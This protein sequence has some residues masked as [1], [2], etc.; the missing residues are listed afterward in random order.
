MAEEDQTERGLSSFA[1]EIEDI[2]RKLDECEYEDIRNFVYKL[3][4]NNG[5]LQDLEENEKQYV[6]KWE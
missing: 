6:P 2:N 1:N 4:I 3:C 5:Y